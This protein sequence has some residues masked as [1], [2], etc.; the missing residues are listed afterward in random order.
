VI[1]DSRTADYQ[2]SGV[3]VTDAIARVLDRIAFASLCAFVFAM[4]WEESIPLVGGVVLARWIGLLAF[5]VLALRVAVTDR[6]RKPSV[7]HVLMCALVVWAAASIFWTI[8][9]QSTLMRIGTY[10]QLLAAVWTIWELAVIERRVF[11]VLE[12]Y[13]LGTYVLAVGT[14]YNYAMGVQAA[15]LWAEVGRVKWHDSRYTMYGVN[16]NDLGLMLALSVPMS[17]YLL[18]RRKSMLTTVLCWLHLG[19]CLTAILLSGS[20]GA[21]LSVAVGLGLFPLVIRHLPRWHRW[22]LLLGCAAGLGCGIYLLPETTWTRFLSIDTAL[23]EGTMSHRT[24]LWSAGLEAFRNHSLIGVGAG[25]YGA[26]ILRAMDMSYPAHNTFL[27]VLVELG[28]AGALLL[29]ALLASLYY[30]ALRM[31]YVEK[32]F[33]IVLLTTWVVGVSALTWEY[34]KP[35]WL[36]FGLLAAHM[37]T[38]HAGRA[39]ECP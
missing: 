23:S 8:D 25:A 39:R 11:I 1:A 30:S 27:S 22:I 10:V 38:S 29:L 37:Y 4:P 31:P 36:L 24:Q 5:A 7:L 18:T 20:R 16:E 3:A 9:R 13:I 14:I 19:I 12:S 35:T 2:A 21:L 26:A 33:W 17:I 34:Y 15:D 28:V 6:F 32:C